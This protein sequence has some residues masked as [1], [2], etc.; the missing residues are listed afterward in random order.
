MDKN[1]VI[2]GGGAAGLMAAISAA[3]NKNSDSINITILEHNDRV[4]KKILQTGNGRCNF[5]NT[6]LTPACYHAAADS[7]A[8]KA[9][10]LFDE[11]KTIDFFEH[12][13]GIL[14]YIKDGY[15]YPRSEQASAVLDA[16]RIKCEHLNINIITNCRIKS[17]CKKEH[18]IIKTSIKDFN[19]DKLIIATGSR[20]VPIT[21]SDGSGYELLRSLGVIINK[22]LPALCAL[23]CDNKAFFKAV[24]GVRVKAK[25]SIYSKEGLLASD[26]GELQLTDYGISGIPAFQVSRYASRALD[27]NKKIY[28]IINFA[29]DIADIYKLIKNRINK[30]GDITSAELGIG[31]INKKLWM[32]LLKMANIKPDIKANKLGDADIKKLSDILET[33]KLNIISTAGYDKAQVCTG[34]AKTSEIDYKTMSLKKDP[35]LYLAGE[36]IDIDGKCGGYNLQWAWTSGYIAGSSCVR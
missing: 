36:I 26:K 3:I 11:R 14:S 17:I 7:F 15:V 28:A 6:F 13:L 31:F 4:G 10:D 1:I 18:F 22:P 25:L 34:G 12:E 32:A 5:T 9:I 33:L 21:G 24:S 16:L 8:M 30:L 27:A 29:S 23:Y 20:A 35:D 2:I 19:A